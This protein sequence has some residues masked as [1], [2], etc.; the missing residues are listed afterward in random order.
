MP[1]AL[2][3]VNSDSLLPLSYRCR[4]VNNRTHLLQWSNKEVMQGE[5]EKSARGRGW[6]EGWARKASLS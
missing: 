4:G 5:L 2:S 1:R 3:Q 6:T